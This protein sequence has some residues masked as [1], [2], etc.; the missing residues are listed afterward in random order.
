MTYWFVVQLVEALVD[1]VMGE[2][3]GGRLPHW[4]KVGA[5]VAGRGCVMYEAYFSLNHFI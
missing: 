4:P 5:G 3:V 1:T 2:P